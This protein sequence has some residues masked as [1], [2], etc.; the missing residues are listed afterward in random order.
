MMRAKANLK[1][2]SIKPSERDTIDRAL[3][4]FAATLERTGAERILEE[5]RDDRVVDEVVFRAAGP[6]K[7][8]CQSRRRPSFGRS[9]GQGREVRRP[10]EPGLRRIAPAL[11]E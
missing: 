10:L 2:H 7:L 1:P 6:A 4:G 8:A 3:L 9:S 11:V 5:F